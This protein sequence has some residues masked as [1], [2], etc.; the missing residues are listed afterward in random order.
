MELA[1]AAAEEEEADDETTGAAEAA[2]VEEVEPTSCGCGCIS[3][4]DSIS[5][6]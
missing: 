5:A 3:T 1:A 6:V 4:P 2:D